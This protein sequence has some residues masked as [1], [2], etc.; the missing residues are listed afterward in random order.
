MPLRSAADFYAAQQRRILAAIL[1]TRAEWSK[2][3]KP[4]DFDRIATRLFALISTA[5]IGAAADAGT[6]VPA[7]LSEQGVVTS[8]V[9]KLQP[10]AFAGWGYSTTN[11]GLA[12]PLESLLQVVPGMAVGG[13]LAEQMATGGQFLDLLTKTQVVEA[14]RMATAAGISA[15]PD[16]GW[17]R[18]VNPPCCQNCAVLAGKF[19][20]HNA[21]FQRHHGCDCVHC[22][23]KGRVPDGYTTSINPDQIHDLTEAQRRALADGADPSQVVNAYRQ[24]TPSARVKMFETGE[25]TTRRGYASYLRRAIDREQGR[26]TVETAVKVGPRGAVRNYT[27]R[28]T[29]R[30]LTP[31]GIYAIARN[32]KEVLLLL[33]KNGYIVGDIAKLARTT[34]AEM[35]RI[36]ATLP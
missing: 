1:G 26:R 34:V 4:A 36:A 32:D 18:H 28:R 8:T 30:R 20:R 7:A 6:Y 29:Q 2:L 10:V 23:A 31:E 25:G 22:P 11:A 9:A 5:Q 21:G 3:S 15:Q 24:A 13:T 19:F 12:Q 35:R 27:E 16:T 33:Q 14:G 17:V